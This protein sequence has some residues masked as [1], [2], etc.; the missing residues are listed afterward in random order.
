MKIATM[1]NQ[2]ENKMSI[3]EIA[4]EARVSITT[5]SRYFNRP[6]KV[7]ASAA[8]RI[9]QVA[10]KLNYQPDIRR[11]GPKTIERVGIRTGMIAFLAL[12]GSSPEEMLRKPALPLLLGSIQCA[13]NERNLSLTMAHPGPN[14][15]LPNTLDPK[16]CDGVILFAR[17]EKERTLKALQKLFQKLPAIWC[18]RD[19]ADFKNEV[20]HIFYDNEAVGAIAADYL[21]GR[22]HRSVAVFNE[23]PQHG[24]FSVRVRRF[25][26]TAE[27]RGM[28]AQLFELPEP[29]EPDVTIGFRELAEKFLRKSKN[30]TGAFF[31]SDDTMLGV[32]GELRAK[33]YDM[34]KL[35][36]VGVN[37]DEVLLRYISP[38]PATIDI[39]MPK[40]GRL[41][42]EQ[43]LRRI[44]GDRAGYHSEIYIKPELIP[45]GRQTNTSK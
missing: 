20:D 1:K 9:R 16:F 15:E 10:A 21:A 25:L 29:T 33:G 45:G 5:V 37:A 41:A 6:E 31:C 2:K 17:P 43:L 32:Y 42:V 11:P 40:L 44:N 19:H 3:V 27:Q 30:I 36:V 28:K 12:G 13:L 7:S 14:G 22:K 23:S 38:R 8:E 24:A 39:K 35:D 18:F 4:N 26:S 34:N